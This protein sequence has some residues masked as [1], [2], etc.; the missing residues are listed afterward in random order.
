MVGIER[1][2]DEWCPVVRWLVEQAVQPSRPDCHGDFLDKAGA[3]ITTESQAESFAHA[4]Q[5]VALQAWADLGSPRTKVAAI[6]PTLLVEDQD[7]FEESD[8][9]FAPSDSTSIRNDYGTWLAKLPVRS[10]S[11]KPLKDVRIGIVCRD[12]ARKINGGGVE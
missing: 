11:T 8:I 1:L 10:P 3:I 9:E 12:A 6:K 5:T 7:T 2:V 4:G